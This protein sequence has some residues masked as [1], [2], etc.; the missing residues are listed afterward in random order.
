MV[1]I[2]KY[3]PAYKFTFGWQ[4][5]CIGFIT[6]YATRWMKSDGWQSFWGTLGGLGMWFSFEYSLMYW[7]ERMGVCY[8]WNGSYPEYLI[9]KSTIV[10][11][12]MVFTYLLFQ[13]SVRCNFIY[14]LRRTFRLMRTKAIATGKIGNYGPRTAFEYIMITWTFYLL[15]M[16]AYDPELVFGLLL[17][18]LQAA[19]LRQVRRQ[20]ALC[21][22][23]C[24]HPVERCG[25]TGQVGH[26]QGT[27]GPYQLAYH[28]RDYRRFCHFH[29]AHYQ[30]SSWQTTGRDRFKRYCVIPMQERTNHSLLLLIRRSQ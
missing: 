7:G 24:Y 8:S 3:N 6:I 1:L 13:E 5:F 21:H 26:A 15:L 4:M 20:P 9:M 23:H 18:L 22:S 29:L 19:G 16:I 11:L 2:E 25:D 30:G 10:M 12:M 27:M 14:F 17:P 28:E